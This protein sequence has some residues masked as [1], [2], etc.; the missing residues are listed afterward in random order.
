MT[1]AHGLLLAGGLF[2]V[3]LIWRPVITLPW[4]WLRPNG[5]NIGFPIPLGLIL[6]DP[7]A[8][9]Y[10][11]VWAQE[12]AEVPSKMGGNWRRW[13]RDK[14]WRQNAGLFGKT[15]EVVVASRCYGA[16][17]RARIE[18]EAR[19]LKTYPDFR[20]WPVQRIVSRMR[21]LEET[22]EEWVDQNKA[23]IRRNKQPRLAMWMVALLASLAIAVGLLWHWIAGAVVLA[24]GLA[25][26]VLL[27]GHAFFG[28]P[29]RYQEPTK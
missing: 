22:A 14:A 4:R 7:K 27:F 5:R 23:A 12:R 17:R 6:M 18:S 24:A 10:G 21:D 13:R 16:D 20:D 3:C 9:H 26:I 8:P 15:V 11:A 29:A 28:D 2:A 1:I 19:G 25:G